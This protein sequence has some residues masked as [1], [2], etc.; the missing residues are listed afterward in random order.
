VAT[1]DKS[2]RIDALT[3]REILG[4]GVAVDP[5]DVVSPRARAVCGTAAEPDRDGLPLPPALEDDIVAS[6]VKSGNFV[7]YP[8]SP[9]QLDYVS[10]CRF[11]KD[12]A[13]ERGERW[14]RHREGKTF[15]HLS[16][17]FYW[18]YALWQTP[19]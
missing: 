6:L 16:P 9:A 10:S 7:D 5:E 4:E 14:R 13:A 11:C 8:P 2:A 19:P 18:A 12:T 1:H 3:G 15:E 17:L